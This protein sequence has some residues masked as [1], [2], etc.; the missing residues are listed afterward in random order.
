MN[1]T[2]VRP[3]LDVTRNE[4]DGFCRSLRLRPRHDPTNGDTNLLRN[5]LRQEAIPAI[6]RAT[7]RDVMRTFARTADPCDGTRP[8]CSRSRT[9][10]ARDARRAA[11]RADSRS[12]PGRCSTCLPALSSRVVRRGFQRAD[13]G[14]DHEAIDARPRPGGRVPRVGRATSRSATKARRTRTH[15]VV[16]G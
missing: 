4:V 12:A 1:G 10:Y 5:A 3:L 15:V 14:W 7:G 16:E 6:E 2:L 13:L 11:R 9:S 8:R